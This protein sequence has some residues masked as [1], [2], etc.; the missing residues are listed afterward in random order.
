[1]NRAIVIRSCGDPEI[2]GAIVDGLTKR[3]I[4]LDAEELAAI[5][6]ENARL[7]DRNA[8]RAYG[9]EKRLRNAR[10]ELA[11]KYAPESHGRAYRAILGAWGGMWA[12]IYGAYGYLSAWNRRG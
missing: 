12:M 8:L 3:V 9:D 11:A 5:K 1:M 10:Q 6:A 2:A 4:P 7:K